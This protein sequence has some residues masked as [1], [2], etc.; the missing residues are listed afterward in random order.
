MHTLLRQASEWDMRGRQGTFPRCKKQLPGDDEM[1]RLVL[2][3]I[4][5]VH[6]F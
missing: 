4:G 1:Q 2:D 6:N 5:L 3:D